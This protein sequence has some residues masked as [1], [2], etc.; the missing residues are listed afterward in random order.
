[1]IMFCAQCLSGLDQR[2][3]GSIPTS[4]ETLLNRHKKCARYFLEAIFSR[5][6]SSWALSSG[7]NSSQKSH[8]SNTGRISISVPPS[9]GARLSHSTASSIDLTCHSQK[10]AISSLVSVNGPSITVRFSPENLTRL[11]FEVG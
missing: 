2:E 5:S 3:L 10:P 11:P 1:M 4:K 8:A 6:R 9:K 7:E